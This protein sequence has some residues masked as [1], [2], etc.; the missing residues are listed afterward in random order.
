MPVKKTG[1]MPGRA[2]QLEDVAADIARFIDALHEECELFGR[3]VIRIPVVHEAS[4]GRIPEQSANHVGNHA[5][6]IKQDRSHLR[7]H[8]FRAKTG[9][10][11]LYHLDVS[12]ASLVSLNLL[13]VSF[14][15]RTGDPLSR[16]GSHSTPRAFVRSRD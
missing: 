6:G 15:N 2:T 7:V 1:G 10:R 16:D 5:S 13:A 11:L 3:E 4:E 9:I 12:A 14:V 8:S